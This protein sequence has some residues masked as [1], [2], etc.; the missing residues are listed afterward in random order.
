MNTKKL[1]TTIFCSRITKPLAYIFSA[2]LLI[3]AC[4]INDPIDDISSPG[5]VAANIYWDVPVTNV[6]AGKDVSFYAEYWSVDNKFNDLSIWYDVNKNL[7]YTL[8]YPPTG[9]TL[10]IDSSALVR[11]F[12]EIKSLDH[13]DASYDAEKKAYVIENSFPVSYT[14]SSL[15]YKNPIAF[16]PEQFNQLIPEYVKTQF[17]DNLFEQF[18]YKDFKSLLVDDQ[19]IVEEEIFEGYFDTITEGE[20]T[21]RVIKPEAETSLRA[22]M[23][24]VSFGVFIYNTNKQFYAVEFTQGYQLN[25]RL[26][27]VNGNNVENFSE[28]K[29]ITVS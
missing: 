16:N 12:I 3:T 4:T 10:T 26:R 24:E 1:R 15:E 29:A 17:L 9:Y 18:S 7:K 13:S 28:T 27:I 20:E 21:I 11:E 2:F 14:L 19:Q 23:N 6:M 5:Y 22:H 25:A 8:S